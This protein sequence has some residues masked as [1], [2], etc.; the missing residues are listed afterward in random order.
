M[1]TKKVIK[2]T[3]IITVA[4]FVLHSLYSYLYRPAETEAAEYFET[5]DGVKAT[6][7]VVRNETF[8]TGNTG[9]V[10]HFR[11]KDGEKVAKQGIVADVYD[12]AA[13]SVTVSRLEEINRKINN[14]E[15]LMA[16][17]SVSAADLSVANARVNECLGTLIKSSSGGNLSNCKAP[18]EE[19]L[20]A[21]CRRQMITGEQTDFTAQL[22]ALKAEQ[23]SLSASLPAASGTVYAESAGYFLSNVDGYE[24]VLSNKAPADLTPKFLSELKAEEKNAEAIGKIVSD[25]EWYIACTLSLN[26]SMRYKDGDT[27]TILTSV[28]GAGELK[29]QVKAINVSPDSDSAVLVL[30]CGSLSKELASMRKGS[31]TIVSKSYSGLKIPKKALR[32]VNEQTGVYVQSGASQKFTPVNVLYTMEDYVICEQRKTEENTLRLYDE[33]VVNRSK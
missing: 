21:I 26:D 17:N 32:V 13:T 18:T 29:T 27:L 33:V 3:V 23:A 14:L 9:G 16:Y 6:G 2:W 28:K 15:Q 8:V 7:I 30:S 11:L 4:V 19:L 20:S 22:E 5:V 10:L 12:S 1:N 24:N 31:F 25:Y